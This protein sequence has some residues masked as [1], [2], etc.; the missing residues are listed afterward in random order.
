VWLGDLSLVANFQMTPWLVARIGYQALFLTGV[1]VASDNIETNNILLTSGPIQLD[2]RSN[3]A[4]H[5][6]LIGLM[7]NW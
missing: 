4:L 3:M 6:P 5:G 1:A 2:D 7:G